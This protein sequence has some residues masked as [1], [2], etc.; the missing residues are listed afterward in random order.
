[1]LELAACFI[2]L[3]ATR[4][5]DRQVGIALETHAIVRVQ[6]EGEFA[7]SWRF[8]VTHPDDRELAP[9]E[10][11]QRFTGAPIEIDHWI[12]PDLD[13]SLNLR[14]REIVTE[15]AEAFAFRF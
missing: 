4:G 3:L 7:R 1:E 5:I 6:C 8:E 11:R 15:H 10:P 9:S 14:V 12:D 13:W 2:L